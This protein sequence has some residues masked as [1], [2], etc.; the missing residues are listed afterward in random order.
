MILNTVKQSMLVFLDPKPRIIFSVSSMKMLH[1]G[2]FILDILD[3][4]L[5]IL[6]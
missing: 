1:R 4:F 2:I 5:L 6:D 3:I